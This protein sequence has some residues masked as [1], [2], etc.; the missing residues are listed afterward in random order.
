[1][2]GIHIVC[3]QP[4]FLHINSSDKFRWLN[5][6]G[7]T[8]TNILHSADSIIHLNGHLT[9]FNWNHSTFFQKQ[10]SKPLNVCKPA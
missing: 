2:I 8:A 4:T 6:I 1:M 10:L 7:N 3:N 5:R 9:N